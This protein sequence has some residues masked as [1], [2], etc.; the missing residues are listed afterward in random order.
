MRQGLQVA[1]IRPRIVVRALVALLLAAVFLAVL[2][3]RVAQVDPGAVFA[4]IGAV[5][6]V[7]WTGAALATGISFWAHAACAGRAAGAE[8]RLPVVCKADA[9]MAATARQAGFRA[10]AV[11]REAWLWPQDFSCDTPARAGLR[12]KLRRGATSGV[13][14]ARPFGADLSVAVMGELAGVNAAWVT[15]RGPEFGFSMGRF[16]PG[17]V[18]GQ[19]VFVA[20]VGG[21]AVGFATFH[22]GDRAWSLDLLRPLP[23][24]PDGTTQMLVV[25]ALAA[26]RG[27]G[28]ARLSLAEAPIGSFSDAQGLVARATRRQL[29][30]T[31]V[32]LQQFKAGFDPRWQTLYITAPGYAGLALAGWEIARRVH[33][34]LPV[35]KLRAGARRD[36][37]YEFASARLPWHR[38]SNV[39]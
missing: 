33:R 34:P 9:R 7:T 15:A 24:C 14:V 27:E 4:A 23:G 31:G 28:V 17:Y 36:E 21:R 39:G 19:R 3:Q 8:A 6:P 10:L 35:V 30:G 37:E 12:R 13:T 18:R 2:V 32:G 25:A 1:A 11:A 16:D 26:A 20:R 5:G 38:M 22:A 29:P